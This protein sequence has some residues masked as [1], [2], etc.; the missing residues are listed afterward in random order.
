M[1]V[2]ATLVHNGLDLYQRTFG[3]VPDIDRERFYSEQK[4]IAYACGVPERHCP[5]T[6]ADFRAYVERVVR[7]ELRP[8][9]IS[10]KLLDT[11]RKLPMPW[12]LGPAYIR[13]NLLAAGALLPSRLRRELDIPWNARRALAFA[14]LIEANRATAKVTPESVRHRPTD[15]VVNRERPLRIFS[16]TGGRRHRTLPHRAA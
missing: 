10:A 14:A 11:G 6:H 9:A 2:W 12:P 7:E 16:Q 4:L 1:W 15:Y 13:L 3:R 5:E 8:T